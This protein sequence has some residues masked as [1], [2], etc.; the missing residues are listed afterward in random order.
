MLYF[1]FSPMTEIRH[2]IRQGLPNC[3]LDEPVIGLRPV[4]LLT[5]NQDF[6]GLLTRLA[7]PSE[8]NV[9]SGSPQALPGPRSPFSTTRRRNGLSAACI[10]IAMFTAA[11]SLLRAQ[12]L[13][14][15][16]TAQGLPQILPSELPLGHWRLARNRNPGGTHGGK[17]AST[18]PA[19]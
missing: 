16:R 15:S 11:N 7:N 4:Q 3:S 12:K 1:F 8:L 18:A 19:S 5:K 17:S 10:S 9:C 2:R 6:C 14:L 13:F